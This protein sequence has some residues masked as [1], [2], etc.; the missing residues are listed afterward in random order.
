MFHHS[1]AVKFVECTGDKSHLPSSYAL[2]ATLAA[3]SAEI[4]LIIENGGY[5]IPLS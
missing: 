3:M 4:F 2:A 5:I 1:G